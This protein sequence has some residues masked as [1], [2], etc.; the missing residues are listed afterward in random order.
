MA[1][2]Q[3]PRKVRP[4]LTRRPRFFVLKGGRGSAKS[5]SI[6]RTLLLLG[7]QRQERI[8]C[9]REYMVSL[10][11]SVHKLLCDQIVDLGLTGFYKVT[12]NSIIGLNGTEF[13]F[14]GLKTNIQSIKSMERLTIVW[15]EE[16]QTVSEESYQILLPTV[17][18]EGSM[19]LVS[20]NPCSEKDATWQRFCIDPPDDAIVIDLNWR[21]NPWFGKTLNAERLRD[22][23]RLDEEEYDWIWEG[24][25][26]RISN[27]CIFRNRI[28]VEEFTAPDRAQFLYGAD[29]GHGVEGDPCALVRCYVQDKRL[30]VDYEAGGHELEL[31]ELPALYDTVPGSRKWKI[32]CDSSRPESITFLK[33]RGFQAIACDKW[34]GSVDDGIAHL[35]SYEQIVV[36]PRCTHLIEEFRLYSWKVDR[37]T[38]EILP[39]PV[40]KWNHFI[41]SLRYALSAHMRGK[42]SLD[43]WAR[44]AS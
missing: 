37:V 14:A 24:Q 23:E 1:C 30:Y 15:I 33:K 39:I 29:F 13:L 10:A 25:I 27:A 28:T 40:D 31:D 20:F 22:K 17:R 7:T 3:F 4:L 36:H 16:A 38:N 8:L 41:D 21:D 11:A 26:R 44:L 9:C 18:T 42:T 5:W 6:A 12:Q 35:K 34:P 2:L 43:Q 32:R 19:I